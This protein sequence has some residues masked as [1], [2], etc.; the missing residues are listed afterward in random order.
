MIFK[1]CL[2]IAPNTVAQFSV[3]YNNVTQR[4]QYNWSAPSVKNGIISSYILTVQYEGGSL[5]TFTVNDNLSTSFIYNVSKLCRK[6]TARIKATTDGGTGPETP[7]EF[8]AIPRSV[9]SIVN[10]FY[11]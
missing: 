1:L 7:I 11:F 6:Y 3:I 10:I 4:A 8:L 9:F 2:N 5:Q